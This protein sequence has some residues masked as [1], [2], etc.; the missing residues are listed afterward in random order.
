MDKIMINKSLRSIWRNKKS[1]FSGIFVLAIGLSLFIGMLSGFMIYTESVRLYH[2][3]TNFADAFATVRAM[4]RGS[5]DRLTRIDGI[6]QAEGVLKHAVNARLDGFDEIIG[7]RI[8]GIDPLRPTTINQFRYIGEPLTE[9]NDIW[10]STAFYNV[11]DLDVGDTIRLLIN[12]RYENFTIRGTV[13]SPEY[14]FVPVVGGGVSDD[15]LNTVGF[16]R[17]DVAE[18]IAGT[19]GVVTNVSL[20]FDE[21]T[22]LEDVEPFLETAMARYGLINIVDRENHFSY[23][24][25]ISQGQTFEMMGTQFPFLFLSIAIGMLYTT[26][27]RLITLERTEIGTMKAMGFSGRYIVGGY[28]LQGTLAAIMSF[29]L[30]VGIGWFIGSTFYGLVAEFFDLAWLPFRLNATIVAAGFVIALTASIL[31][32]VMGA[33]TS[34]KVQPAEAMREAPPSPKSVKAGSKFNGWFSK[35]LLDTGGK[36]ALRS[37]QRNKKRVVITVVSIGIIFTFMNVF[38]TIDEFMENNLYTVFE[39]SQISDGTIVLNRPEPSSALIRDI[40]QMHGVLE[41][42]TVLNMPLE[43]EGGGVTRTLG[44]TGIAKDATLFNIFDLNGN[45]LRTDSGGL[46]LSKFWADA[47]GVELGQK[48]SVN[49]PNFHTNAYVEVTQIFESSSAG[50]VYMEITELSMLFGSETIANS[51]QINAVEG[52]LPIIF[53]QLADAGNVSGLNS[54][55]RMLEFIRV[56]VDTNRAITAIF[57]IVAIIICFAVVYNISSIA[58]GEKQREYATLR[59]LGFQAPAVTEINTFEYV[60]MLLLGSIEGI[61]GS[62]IM[63]PIITSAFG[64]EHTVIDAGL[65]LMPTLMTFAC[66]ALAVAIS[67]FLTGRQIRKFNLVDVLK[68]R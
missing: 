19:P 22:T 4:P 36:L 40:G 45:Q 52:Y 18:N 5:V 13:L 47:F 11:H 29:V 68:E 50:P 14:L 9:S 6:N 55:E 66:C 61:I 15:S 46:I 51:V 49:H 39:K 17:A 56:N 53:D 62:I 65:S 27:K 10:V 34:L 12:G 32:V 64:F 30:A 67:C 44:V 8:V 37:M 26:L 58:L 42:E 43:F 60:I 20:I 54:S 25:L 3:E 57:V 16:V 21:S 63:I 59:V 23:M 2:E 7:V 35:L 38:F 28:L 48:I 24:V 1:Y 33:K 41:I 31:G